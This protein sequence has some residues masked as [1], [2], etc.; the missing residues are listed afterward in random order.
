MESLLRGRRFVCRDWAFHKLLHCVDTRQTA[1]T[2]GVLILGGPGSGKSA[3]CAEIIWPTTTQAAPSSNALPAFSSQHS[4]PEAA[5]RSDSIS[6]S[7]STHSQ[8]TT[9]SNNPSSPISEVPLPLDPR[10]SVSPLKQLNAKSAIRERKLELTSR[11]IAFHFCETHNE[12]SLSPQEFVRSI[13][14]QLLD[15]PLIGQHYR[16][17]TA[18]TE[19]QRKHFDVLFDGDVDR[20]FL[21][22]VLE[23]LSQIAVGPPVPHE[24]G[25]SQDDT[26]VSEGTLQYRIERNLFILVDGLDESLLADA[27]PPPLAFD[28]LLAV[29]STPESL[30]DARAATPPLPSPDGAGAN[31]VFDKQQ[32]PREG[33]SGE[34]HE[35]NEM[36]TPSRTIVE[37]IAR[38]HAHFPKWL[39]AICTVRRA[40]KWITRQFI[41]WRTIT[42][43]DLKK[44]HVK[45][46][47]QQY[48]ITRL[49]EVESMRPLL[50]SREAI[51]LLHQLQIKSG[52]SLLY[53]E[54][55]L[56]GVGDGSISMREVRDIPGTL[57]GLFLWL[58]QR[59]FARKQQF[60]LVRPVLDVLVASGRALTERDL[61][62]A[63]WARDRALD[64]L[65]FLSRLES[66]AKLLVLLA[67]PQRQPA[68]PPALLLFHHSFADWLL[69][70]K[71]CTQKYL[72]NPHFGHA[73]LAIA[74][75]TTLHC[76]VSERSAGDSKPR[77][78]CESATA[79]DQSADGQLSSSG[80]MQLGGHSATDSNASDT[81]A[82]S[83]TATCIG[84]RN[85]DSPPQTQPEPQASPSS[86]AHQ[87]PLT[88]ALVESPAAGT[89]SV[90]P[91]ADSGSAEGNATSQRS[92]RRGPQRLRHALIN[93]TL[94]ELLVHLARAMTQ[95]S[96][97]SAANSSYSY[98]TLSA[99][100]TLNARARPQSQS[101][102][103]AAAAASAWASAVAASGNVH[104][105]LV[106]LD[107]LTKSLSIAPHALANDL[108]A[109]ATAIAGRFLP[110]GP[111]LNPA[112]PATASYHSATLN[113]AQLHHFLH[114]YASLSRNR[115][116]TTAAAEAAA[117]VPP[118]Q[119][120]ANV[121]GEN[122]GSSSNNNN[123]M[124]GPSLSNNLAYSLPALNRAT[125]SQS[126]TPD[127]QMLPVATQIGSQS[128]AAAAAAAAA[129]ATCVLVPAPAP[130]PLSDAELREKLKPA[131]LTAEHLALWLLFLGVRRHH[132]NAEPESQPEPIKPEKCTKSA[133]PEST[134]AAAAAEVAILSDESQS[135]SAAPAATTRSPTPRTVLEC[136]QRFL[137]V[138][139]PSTAPGAR[140]PYVH[141]SAEQAAARLRALSLPSA[142][143]NN[144]NKNVLALAADS[145]DAAGAGSAREAPRA[146]AEDQVDST[147]RAPPT[148]SV[149]PPP[150]P[151]RES[152]LQTEHEE[153]VEEADLIGAG[154]QELPSPDVPV[155]VGERLAVQS[156]SQQ[157]QKQSS[158][159]LGK[160][161]PSHFTAGQLTALVCAASATGD[162][163]ALL[164]L[165][166]NSLEP[167]SLTPDCLLNRRVLEPNAR[168]PAWNGATP[169]TLA[170]R[171]GHVHIVEYLI[172][173]LGPQN[174]AVAALLRTAADAVEN[175]PHSPAANATGAEA[176]EDADDKDPYEN[177]AALRLPPEE[178]AAA[179]AAAAPQPY[180]N[181]EADKQ[182]GVE[183]GTGTR[184]GTADSDGSKPAYENVAVVRRSDRVPTSE[185]GGSG[186]GPSSK[187]ARRRSGRAS[188][189]RRSGA[190]VPL[191]VDECDA[192]GWNAL[193][194]AAWGGHTAAVQL[195]LERGAHV[196]A[197]GPD[198]RSA[199]RAA[200]WGG[201]EEIV[202]LLLLHRAAVDRADNEGRTPLIAAA[203]MGHLEIIE[204][205]VE[206]GADVNAVDSDGRSALSIACMCLAATEQHRHIV[207]L[208]LEHG[209]RVRRS[210]LCS[211]S[212]THPVICGLF[213]SYSV[214]SGNRTSTPSS[215]FYSC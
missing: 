14:R 142:S 53:L 29:Q 106:P 155:L 185:A 209:A 19:A 172:C 117:F 87:Q 206:A 6:S 186:G 118:P 63:L 122:T 178:V 201:H 110:A 180:E 190:P 77:P 127:R 15:S 99:C 65:T 82:G 88:L 113:S 98:S 38:T 62:E 157:Q 131:P 182:P 203:Y 56:S 4:E 136:V 146:G 168:D 75:S 176:L 109:G 89:S 8:P 31:D 21:Q 139:K 161:A 101:D 85:S 189:S 13:R 137:S 144:N 3:L 205:L 25:S 128:P 7:T 196:D 207:E 48:I 138:A 129:A 195:L 30:A 32:P 211:A 70:V 90:Q 45:H 213:Y 105:Q 2:G 130:P 167:A 50:Y 60:A 163:D 68:P 36:R 74:H 200:A 193:R 57:N 173:E 147:E 46:D 197:C 24:E 22:G 158:R 143:N 96:L 73:A 69:D 154:L 12:H 18:S 135:P 170:A 27:V 148:D 55:V 23:P 150:L 76:L 84:I 153:V 156:Q 121:N 198:R 52:A 179:G 140:L 123:A 67:P 100:N 116:P 208:L 40:S 141:T 43:D 64:Y 175:A 215:S 124:P 83:S 9:N 86:P 202:R 133:A 11:L 104:V 20:A 162:L 164:Q 5:R 66:L 51:E 192:E 111:A 58:S 204:L 125:R 39:T 34:A 212:Y 61:F 108:S 78:H 145:S 210:A 181:L 41:G 49:E 94:R 166:G 187:R 160:E 47:V 165:F 112:A 17:L 171:N 92:D 97:A 42:L 79:R 28:E 26:I 183:N 1:K 214:Y 35:H 184:S 114:Q 120:N 152:R 16:E 132:F 194:S 188:S 59:L 169:L 54:T 95:S 91:A 102:A 10:S 149:Q 126:A 134:A 159:A 103:A 119:A 44:S 80:S 81:A 115:P 177:L 71:L 93:A 107:P 174:T 191:R 151:A 37:L 72:C 199:L 33:A